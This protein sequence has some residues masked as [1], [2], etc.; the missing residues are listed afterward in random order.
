MRTSLKNKMTIKNRLILIEIIS[1]LGM[2]VIGLVAIM[3]SRKINQAS[4][5]IAD[6]WVPSAIAAEQLNTDTSDYRIAE[7][8]YILAKRRNQI[9]ALE[10]ELSLKRQEIGEEF[11]QYIRFYIG[12]GEEDALIH[13]A[14][15]L[16]QQYE[17]VSEEILEIS[18]ANQPDKALELLNGQSKELFDEYS[19]LLKAIGDEKQAGA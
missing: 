4:T 13:Q 11:D 1:I 5:D 9:D 18:R 16:W 19:R 6:F 12:G 10:A 14:Q 2:I 3:T 17:A 7:H 15:R 8:E